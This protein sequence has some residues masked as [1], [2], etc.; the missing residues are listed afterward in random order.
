M[1]AERRRG[2]NAV[3]DDFEAAHD[4][5]HEDRC[6][7]LAEFKNLDDELNGAMF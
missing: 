3:D 7:Y 6:E 5:L 1:V 4:A 2:A